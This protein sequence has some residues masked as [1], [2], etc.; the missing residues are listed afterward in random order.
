[1]QRSVRDQKVNENR[2]FNRWLILGHH[3]VQLMNDL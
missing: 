2:K 3:K 1:M